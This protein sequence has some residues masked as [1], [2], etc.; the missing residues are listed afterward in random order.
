MIID[1]YVW[2]FV[3]FLCDFLEKKICLKNVLSLISIKKCEGF[4]GVCIK[5]EFRQLLYNIIYAQIGANS[6]V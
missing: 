6:T 5:K 1:E 2:L 3:I 4:F